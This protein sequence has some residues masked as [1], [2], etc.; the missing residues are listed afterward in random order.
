MDEWK[1]RGVF[2]DISNVFD[3]PKQ[4]GVL[5]KLKQNGVSENMLKTMSYFL[6]IWYQRIDFNGQI[7][8]W[9]AVNVN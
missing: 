2:V 5:L 4:Q 3:K 1:V 8:R 9:T 7:S 6:A